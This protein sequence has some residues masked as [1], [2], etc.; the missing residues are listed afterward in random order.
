MAVDHLEDNTGLT[1]TCGMDKLEEA[2]PY[3][4]RGRGKAMPKIE[5]ENLHS[6]SIDIFLGVWHP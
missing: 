3:I 1:K 2:G 4:D 6:S 5:G